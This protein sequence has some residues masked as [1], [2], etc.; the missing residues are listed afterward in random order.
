MLHPAIGHLLFALVIGAVALSCAAADGFAPPDESLYPMGR[1]VYERNCQVCHGRWGDGDGEM[2]KGMIPKPRQFS[3][4]I[5]KYR[6]TPPG[7]LPTTDDL[8]RTI[9]QGR[10]NTSMPFFSQLSDREVRAVA[11]FIKFF[12]P[13]WRKPEN[14]GVPIKLP[15]PPA[16][17]ARPAEAAA[18]ADQGRVTFALACASCHGEHGNG[19]GPAAVELKDAWGDPARPADLRAPAFR[20]GRTAVDIFRVLTLGVGGTP[21]ASF[22]DTL[23]EDQ[24]WELAAFVLTL[25]LPATTKR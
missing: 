4:G 15:E 24:R 20:N 2:A 12:S 14:H 9:R 16:W 8:I 19:Q 18:R 22:A 6:S 5:F 23:T 21:M 7:C 25:R 3:A 17:L 11:E 10:A 13:R 1:H